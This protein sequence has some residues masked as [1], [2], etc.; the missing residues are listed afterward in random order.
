M[1]LFPLDFGFHPATSVRP[2][3]HG[4]L[5]FFE[6]TLLLK[7]AV[8]MLEPNRFK[9]LFLNVVLRVVEEMV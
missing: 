6:L 8:S 2:L 1:F 3:V 4:G 7:L 5:D 9:L